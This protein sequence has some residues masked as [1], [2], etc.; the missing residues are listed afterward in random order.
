MKETSRAHRPYNP[1]EQVPQR[2]HPG[3]GQERPARDHNGVD[4]SKHPK[5]RTFAPIRAADPH[6][7][8]VASLER[9]VVR[10]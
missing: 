5:I 4:M 3:G 9:I 8:G 7:I 6:D 2:Q 10:V 1:L